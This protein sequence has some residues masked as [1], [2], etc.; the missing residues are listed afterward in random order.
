MKYI[1]EKTI[2][3][4]WQKAVQ[5][6]TENGNIVYDDGHKLKEV[7]N[8]MIEV[9]K[10]LEED[11][12]IMQLADKEIIAWMKNNFLK[13]VPFNDWGYSYGQR[14][15]NYRGVNQIDNII[16]KLIKKRETKSAT[17]V[18]TFPPEDL[19]HNP[20]ITAIDFKY[21]KSNLITTV[22]ARSQDIGKKFCAD[23]ISIT[24]LSKYICN[25]TGFEQGEIICHVASAH[26]YQ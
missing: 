24:E 12:I 7:L 13:T 10:P 16:E 14:L 18:L 25:K 8:L 26:I 4:A 15:F 11:D 17:A 20:C 2:G 22:F 19:V 5:Y 6:V 3:R 23:I 1:K 9:S 21:R